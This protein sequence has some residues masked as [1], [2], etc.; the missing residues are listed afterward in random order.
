MILDI[1]KYPDKRLRKVCTLVTD[2]GQTLQKQIDD[3]FETMYAAPGLG[4]AAIQVGI[5]SRLMVMDVGINEGQI[6]KRN[7]L[8]LVNPQII[9]EEGEITWEEG[10]LSCP[11]LVVPITRSQ[12]IQLESLDRKG[13]PQNFSAEDLLAV[14]IQ[15]EIDHL[16]GILIF[17][18]LSRLKQDL[19]KQKIKKEAQSTKTPTR[20]VVR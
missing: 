10:C 3:M 16:N 18:K 9:S 6:V 11:D 12:K 15:H 8:V 13:K 19:Y 7:P 17:D 20:P 1:L 14:C 2:F 5:F 4:L